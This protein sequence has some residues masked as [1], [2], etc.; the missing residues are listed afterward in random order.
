MGDEMTMKTGFG[1]FFARAR[2]DR[3]GLSLREFCSR[4]GFDAGN[5]SKLERGRLAV[6]QAREVLERY[7]KALGIEAGSD[8]WYQFFDLAAAE[9]GK[10]PA[11]L[12]NDDEVREKLPVLFRTLRGDRVTKE[13]MEGLIDLIRRA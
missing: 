13:Q 1:E 3:V 8:D 2:R 12:L 10:I 5:I 6:P 4:H 9:N 7:A 11:D